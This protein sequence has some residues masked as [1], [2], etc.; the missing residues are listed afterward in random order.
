M[1]FSEAAEAKRDFVAFQTPMPARFLDLIA[2]T[3]IKTADIL[4]FKKTS[5]I[6]LKQIHQFNYVI[7]VGKNC[8]D[9]MNSLTYTSSIFYM[10]ILKTTIHILQNTVKY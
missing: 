6:I 5:F 2:N 7:F 4:V 8:S 9:A 10:R 1:V 3:T